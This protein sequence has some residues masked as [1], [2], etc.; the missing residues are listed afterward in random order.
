MFEIRD[1]IHR[2]ISFSESEKRVIDHPYVQ[3]LRHVRQLGLSYLVYP[4]ATHDRFS[5][6]IGAMHVAGRLWDGIVA[7]SGDVIRKHFGDDDI[8]HFRRL[9]RLAGLLHDLGHPP[10]SHVSEQF[11]PRFRDLELPSGW[12]ADERQDRQ[13]KHE[14]YSVV[15]IAALAAGPEAA[16]SQDEARDI[17]SLVHHGVTPS[18]SWEGRFGKK[19]EGKGGIHRLLRSLISGELDCDRMDYLLRDAYF[20]GAAYGAH[21]IDHLVGNLGVVDHDDMGLRLTID[22]TAVRTFEDFLLA[23][24]HMFIQV[25]MHKTTTAFDHYLDQALKNGEFALVVPGTAKAYAQLR[26]CTLIERLFAAAEDPANAWSRRLVDRHPPKMLLQS[27]NARPEDTTLL[28]KVVAALDAAGVPYFTM[29][30]HQTLSKML[31]ASAP[32]DPEGT[33][34]LVRKKVFGASVY[35]PIERHS[36]LLNKYNE[37]IDITN[38]YVLPEHT[39]EAKR[40]VE[41][42]R[43]QG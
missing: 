28:A 36:S 8:A 19:E 31:T 18:P 23:R 16:L 39:A 25:Y 30:S 6:A 24:Y 32:P 43:P 21:D 7:T 3:R 29:Q 42:L 38:L 33:A 4:G 2:T 10:F 40:A 37:V 27:S 11:M 20:T 1:P 15:L 5:H 9:L 13:A 26:D 22:A 34:M 12:F 14:D 17:A 35:E 41:P